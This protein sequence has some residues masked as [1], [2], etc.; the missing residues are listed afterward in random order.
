MCLQEATV[1]TIKAWLL[2]LPLFSSLRSNSLVRS[3]FW[4]GASFHIRINGEDIKGN[5]FMGLR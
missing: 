5:Y 4:A 1:L 3:S 2:I